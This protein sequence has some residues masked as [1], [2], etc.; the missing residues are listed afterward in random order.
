MKKI[1]IALSLASLLLVV[2]VTPSMAADSLSVVSSGSNS[3]SVAC[4]RD[5]VMNAVHACFLS[6]EQDKCISQMLSSCSSIDPRVTK[7]RAY[8]EKNKSPLVDYAPEFVKYADKYELDW[9]LVASISGVESTFGKHMPKN[10]YNAYGWGN[11]TLRFTSWDQSIEHVTKTLKEKYVDRGV[12]TLPEISRVYCPPNPQWWYK[13]KYFMDQIDKSEVAQA[14]SPSL[15][16][17]Y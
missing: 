14:S 10:S 11:G 16:F 13:V 9:R 4:S 3:S 12:D 7:L 8:F 15:A 5:I 2:K 17:N 6:V 1:I